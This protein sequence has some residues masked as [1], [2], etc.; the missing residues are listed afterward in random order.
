MEQTPASYI[1][2]IFALYMNVEMGGNNIFA[3][4]KNK[5]VI[6]GNT[7]RKGIWSCNP[8]WSGLKS[9]D[10]GNK[11]E[12]FTYVKRI[13]TPMIIKNPDLFL[14]KQFIKFVSKTDIIK[15]GDNMATDIDSGK[16]LII[17]G[18]SNDEND[19]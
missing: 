11:S 15:M 8:K 4:T 1:V 17:S 18:W 9:T 16:L 13:S 12:I 7:N 3:T 5:T 14:Q 10:C 6:R 19:D 2:V